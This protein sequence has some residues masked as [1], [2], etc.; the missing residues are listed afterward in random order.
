MRMKS[1]LWFA[2]VIIVILMI[3]LAVDGGGRDLVDWMAR[4]HGR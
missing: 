1:F 3:A 4:L 2:A